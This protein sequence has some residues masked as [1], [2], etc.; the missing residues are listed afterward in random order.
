ME[1][2]P[3]LHG[4]LSRRGRPS[5]A[6]WGGVLLALALGGCGGGGR[7]SLAVL[8]PPDPP[9]IPQRRPVAPPGVKAWAPAQIAASGG[10]AAP[11]DSVTSAAVTTAPLPQIA[12]ATP[13]AMPT[14]TPP[15]RYLVQPGDTVYG[16]SRRLTVPLRSVI[17]ANSLAPPYALR[18]GQIL[19]IPNPRSHIVAP[20]ETVYAISRQYGIDMSELVRMNGIAPPYTISPGTALIVPAEGARTSAAAVAAAPQAKLQ[21]KPLGKPQTKI[22]PPVKP[23]PPSPQPAVTQPPPAPA[24]AARLA[25][26]PTPPPRAGSKFLWPTNGKLIASYGAKNGGLHNDG[27]NIAAPRGAP[28]RAAENGVVVYSGNELRGFGNLILIKHADGWVTAYAHT[29][30]MSVR[31]GDR[32]RRGQVIGK[33]GSTGSVSKPQLHFEIRKGSQ[34]VDPMRLLNRQNA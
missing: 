4:G 14:G 13:V 6:G 28:V 7:S 29:D 33:V 18:I 1:R 17:D 22:D 5:V 32:V 9:P 24:P 23:A 10:P 34:A 27:I 15:S 20:G 3:R 30:S 19:R 26:I 31:R 8:P 16:I 25:K 21:F 11:G 2:K 12:R